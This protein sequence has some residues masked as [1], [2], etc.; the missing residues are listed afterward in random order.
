MESA[1]SKNKGCL[2]TSYAS[3]LLEISTTT[4]KNSMRLSTTP[5]RAL[6]VIIGIALSFP[7]L[8][9]LWVFGSI[10]YLFAVA[11]Q[12]HNFGQFISI[13]AG[14]YD[15]A[16]VAVAFLVFPI[17]WLCVALLSIQFIRNRKLSTVG[18]VVITLTIILFLVVLFPREPPKKG[19]F[20][21]GPECFLHVVYLLS[22][23]WYA[24]RR[25][26]NL[27]LQN[28]GESPVPASYE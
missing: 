6:W 2:S 16:L 28:H 18:G 7:A 17:Y 15:T 10:F 13:A 11:M 3:K 1:C 23:L 12:G 19:F 5:L 21:P 24:A 27:R 4:S 14:S 20:Y 26:Q 9:E 8:L 25:N 22:L